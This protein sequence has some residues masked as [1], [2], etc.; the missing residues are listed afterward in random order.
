MIKSIKNGHENSNE[1]IELKLFPDGIYL[2]YGYDFRNYDPSSLHRRIRKLKIENNFASLSAITHKI[3]YDPSL[4]YAM[5]LNQQAIDKAKSGIYPL[6]L[7]QKYTS[8]YQKSGGKNEFSDYYTANYGSVIL[9]QALKKNILFPQ[10]NL[11]TE[12]SFNEMNLIT[13]R[14]VL[15]YFNKT[16]Q[17]RVLNLFGDS[18]VTGGFLDLGNSE[19]I[20]SADKLNYL[21]KVSHDEN[22]FQIIR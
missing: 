13:C 22:I 8:N 4:I 19:S 1:D 9:D 16:L 7:L 15:I 6:N 2:K 21:H 17:C 18:L 3:I 20:P 10:H 12:Q 14:N 11:A 5:D